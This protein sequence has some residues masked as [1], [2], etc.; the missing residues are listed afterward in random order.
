MI[1]IDGLK[2]FRAAAERAE[3][4]GSYHAWQ[5]YYQTY[6]A[7]FDPLFLSIYKIDREQIQQIIQ[8]IDFKDLLLRSEKGRSNFQQEQAEKLLTECCLYFGFTEKFSVYM[9]TGLGFSDGAAPPSKDPYIFLGLECLEERDPSILIPHEF[10]HMARFYR[11]R[12]KEDFAGLTVKQLLIAEGLAVWTSLQI[13]GRTE[14]ERWLPNALMMCQKHYQF[15][16]LKIGGLHE[17]IYK[18]LEAPLDGRMV[19]KYFTGTETDGRLGYFA[20]AIIIKRLM[21]SGMSLKD[22]TFMETD[23]ILKI[24]NSLRKHT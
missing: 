23:K 1:I 7:A 19:E 20:G 11:L 18:D 12:E 14:D 21:E 13:S 24:W 5:T 10:S 8:E 9:L 22:L 2:E 17:E 4:E 15:L 6:K 16:Q 3:A